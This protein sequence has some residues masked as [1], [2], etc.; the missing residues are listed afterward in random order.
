VTV[1]HPKI[2]TDGSAGPAVRRR[3]AVLAIGLGLPAIVVLAGGWQAWPLFALPIV[4]SPSL[5]GRRGL[6]G[7]L[8]VAA[9]V[10]ALASGRSG[11]DGAEL[12]LGL[13]GFGLAA[14]AVGS[15]RRASSRELR[16]VAAISFTDR[17]TGLYNY[18]FLMDALKRECRRSDRYGTS[19]AL[20]LFDVD[21]FKAF[22]DRYGH[23]AGNRLLV[24]VARALDGCRRASDVAARYGGEEFAL[25]V[26]GAP[27]EAVQAAERVRAAVAE[28]RIQVQGGE[29]VGVT[30][31]AGVAGYVAEEG[32]DGELMVDRADTSLYWSKENGRDQ[33]SLFS[34]EHRWARSRL[35]RAS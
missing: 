9:L 33:V 4:L 10:F 2:A 3:V 31:S 18:G 29:S 15:M 24:E 35:A 12:T 8:V 7:S 17:L 28:V 6:I 1:T 26:S 5:A 21:R 25:L 22:N 11:P 16:R 32:G 19:L 20:V 34:P 27:E 14:V 23:E 13:V 30:V